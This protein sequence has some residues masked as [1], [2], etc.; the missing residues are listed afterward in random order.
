MPKKILNII[1]Y[2]LIGILA[3]SVIVH[4]VDEKE[5]IE[6]P[7]EG[8]LEEVVFS[9]S[10]NP[11]WL[12]YTV[13]ELK[14]NNNRLVFQMFPALEDIQNMRLE[15]R[16]EQNGKKKESEKYLL[17]SFNGSFLRFLSS[18]RSK[19]FII[20]RTPNSEVFN[21]A[22]TSVNEAF[23]EGFTE[24]QARDHLEMK[25]SFQPALPD[26]LFKGTYSTNGWG[27]FELNESGLK[28]K[29]I[30]FPL[31]GSNALPSNPSYS[32][33]YFDNGGDFFYELT[34]ET[35]NLG[36]WVYDSELGHYFRESSRKLEIK[37]E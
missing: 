37:V 12:N 21:V 15:I 35:L 33:L 6:F 16:F 17:Q 25:H 22:F 3:L 26:S 23:P 2:V 36:R 18:D 20:M 24:V 13:L 14:E 27:D 19:A 4:L 1:L 11:Y 10:K 30:F 8:S 31:V 9:P 28:N 34:L 5:E 7:I 32:A 29:D